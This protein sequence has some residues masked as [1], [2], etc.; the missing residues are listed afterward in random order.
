MHRL[1]LIF[2]S[3]LL[4]ATVCIA[5][6]WVAR[7]FEIGSDGYFYAVICASTVTF[8][9][10]FLVGNLRGR[11][12]IDG[13]FF[14]PVVRIP[15]ILLLTIGITGWLLQ[16]SSSPDTTCV[17][18]GMNCSNQ[19]DD[20]DT[21]ISRHDCESAIRHLETMLSH[22]KELQLSSTAL[23]VLKGAARD[24]AVCPGDAAKKVHASFLELERRYD[25]KGSGRKHP[26]VPLSEDHDEIAKAI[27]SEGT[28]LDVEP[29]DD[30]SAIVITFRQAT[31]NAP[32]QEPRT[33]DA[34]KEEADRYWQLLYRKEMRF[35]ILEILL[36]ALAKLLGF[37]VT[38]EE[39]MKVVIE[40]N[41]NNKGQPL[42]DFL[43]RKNVSAKNRSQL[44]RYL[45]R[46]GVIE[47][48]LDPSFAQGVRAFVTNDLTTGI[49]F[50][51]ISEITSDQS[52]HIR[53]DRNEFMGDLRNSSESER[54]RIVDDVKACIRM[55][56]D[57]SSSAKALK[58]F[59]ENLGK[60]YE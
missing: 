37:D 50:D 14:G 15:A 24:V 38:V 60:A 46:L 8:C 12:N 10:V 31:Q 32:R 49:C 33:D 47:E 54:K 45:L 11:D 4:A 7:F 41:E 9:V 39:I 23:E 26:E 5:G 42:R 44:M 48:E 22:A 29:K 18:D 56:L 25:Q 20:L 51:L 35:S 27:V 53:I 1:F 55:N 13:I 16:N 34:S 40:S 58:Q 57:N 59:H 30:G 43:D 2:D 6:A 52:I 28:E 36:R 17:E 19:N 3:A 21:D